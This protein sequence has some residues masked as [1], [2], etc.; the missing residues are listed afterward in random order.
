MLIPDSSL[1]RREESG[2]NMDIWQPIVFVREAMK[3]RPSGVHH[4][5]LSVKWSVRGLHLHCSNSSLTHHIPIL[6]Y[7]TS[8]ICEN[9]MDNVWTDNDPT[10]SLLCWHIDGTGTERLNISLFILHF[11][12][13][14]KA[15][16]SLK[17][18]HSNENRIICCKYFSYIHK[19][20][21]SV[22]I[23]S[24]TSSVPSFIY[25]STFLL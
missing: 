2:I 23:Y 14:C 13:K 3:N 19:C 25:L 5:W 7:S 10:Y 21:T 16:N 11:T 1:R 8:E 17:R 20:N 24:P 4:C 22:F 6:H 18:L 12:M 15:L 9:N